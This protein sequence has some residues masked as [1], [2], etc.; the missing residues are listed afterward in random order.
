[1]PN[2]V[3]GVEGVACVVSKD[4]YD[5]YALRVLVVAGIDV[6]TVKDRVIPYTVW[7]TSFCPTL[8]SGMKTGSEFDVWSVKRTTEQK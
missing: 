6:D 7:L 4:S 3:V 2:C 1:M 5:T 8:I